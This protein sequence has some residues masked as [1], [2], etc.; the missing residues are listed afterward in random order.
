LVRYRLSEVA[1]WSEQ[2]I[3]RATVLQ[4]RAS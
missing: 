2:W 3:Q 4:R 1:A